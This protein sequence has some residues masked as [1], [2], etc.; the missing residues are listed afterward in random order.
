MATSD[1]R[2]RKRMHQASREL[3]VRRM[4]LP[5]Y[6]MAYA[7]RLA[8]TKPPTICYWLYHEGQDGTSCPVLADR[9]RGKS[10]SYLE[11]IEVAMVATLRGCGV[12]LPKIRKAH[13]YLRTRFETRHPFAHVRIQ[14]AGAEVLY[15]LRQEGPWAEDLEHHLV[16]AS[17]RG[18]IVWK[19]PIRDRIRQFDYEDVVDFAVRW[20]PWGRDFPVVVDPR[21]QFGAPYLRDSGIAT[22]ALKERYEAG[23]SIGEIDDDF[24]IGTTQIINALRFEGIELPAAA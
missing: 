1:E 22:F 15:D 2:R 11:L 14:T 4:F 13:Q 3:W 6:T 24:E 7:A 16:D 9:E 17:A 19:E 5:A 23:A 20:H 8:G 18:Q 21:V 10:L 12:T